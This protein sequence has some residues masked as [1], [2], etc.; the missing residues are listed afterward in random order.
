MYL[1]SNGSPFGLCATNCSC[2]SAAIQVASSLSMTVKILYPINSNNMD[3]F[4]QVNLLKEVFNISHSRGYPHTE[5]QWGTYCKPELVLTS[6]EG[7]EV[8][9]GWGSSR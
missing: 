9:S 1:Q 6:E 7:L 4:I 3:Q 2:V 5:I 8:V